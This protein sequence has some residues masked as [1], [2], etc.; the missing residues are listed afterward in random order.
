MSTPPF[1]PSP[2]IPPPFH[3]LLGIPPS[4]HPLLGISFLF[5]NPPPF[6]LPLVIL[7]FVV[8][9]SHII[10]LGPCVRFPPGGCGEVLLSVYWVWMCVCGCLHGC[11]VADERFSCLLWR[12]KLCILLTRILLFLL[13]INKIIIIIPNIIINTL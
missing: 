9:I 8:N 1:H 5:L 4:F 13:F 10:Y 2:V 3:P 6:H 11:V 7:L 12:N